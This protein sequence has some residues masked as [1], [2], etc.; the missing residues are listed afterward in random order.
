MEITGVPA[1]RR[2]KKR[3]GTAFLLLLGV[4]LFF[5][6]FSNTLQTL[7]LPKVTT[8]KLESRSLEF[9][10]EG[11]GVLRPVSEARLLNSSGWKVRQIL[12]K[13]G[14]KVKKGQK[15]I[16]YDSQTA[17]SELQDEISLLDK[18]EIAQQTLQDQFIQTYLEGDELQIRKARREI[19]AGKL[20]QATQARKIA[21]LREKLTSEQQLKAPFDGIV[22]RLNAIQGMLSAGEPDLV[23][24]N[25]S[26]GYQ[27][28]FTA[29]AEL[30]SSLGVS[31][32]E[33]L[34]VELQSPEG[35]Q[36]RS[37]QGKVT[38]IKDVQARIGSSPAEEN[39]KTEE[40]PQKNVFIVLEDDSLKGGEQ[41]QIKLKKPSLQE[42]LVVPSEAIHQTGERSYVYKIEEQRG[43]LGNVFVARE[44]QIRSSATNGIDS[45]I[46]TD[47]LYEDEMIILESSEPLQ[48]GNRVRLQ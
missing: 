34:E 14:D 38:E 40:I 30:L 28:D 23:I 5:T 10:L 45:V 33:K 27:F 24:S 29:D 12:V 9:T 37:V 32:G 17:E 36:A 39:G 21:G 8:V 41:V 20:D 42:G 19:E 13:E 2:S 16:L 48:D 25:S 31:L 18:Q 6:F 11:S 47:S 7:T 22:T 3:I 44:V 35:P 43:A 26:K 1:D 15:L 46:Q 4:L